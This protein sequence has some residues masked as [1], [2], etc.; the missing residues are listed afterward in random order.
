MWWGGSYPQNLVWVHAAVSEKP[1][2]TDDGRTTDACAMTEALLTKSSRAKNSPRG[3]SG[4]GGGS[5][6]S[7][8]GPND[9]R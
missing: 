1:E 3:K 7:K 8:F 6:G 5:G 4:G 2:F 9:K